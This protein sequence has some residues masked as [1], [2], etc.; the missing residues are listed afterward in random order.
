VKSASISCNS[1]L[2]RSVEYN[3]AKELKICIQNNTVRTVLL[4]KL[5]CCG[6]RSVLPACL[7]YKDICPALEEQIRSTAYVVQVYIGSQTCQYF[8]IQA[9]LHTLF[10]YDRDSHQSKSDQEGLALVVSIWWR[11]DSRLAEIRLQE[12]SD[13]RSIGVI[14]EWAGEIITDAGDGNDDVGFNWNTMIR[15]GLRH[16]DN[17]SITSIHLIIQIKRP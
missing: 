3:F 13:C 6:H 7:H 15:N 11:F 5:G 16:F 14:K 8:S 4:G 12:R 17:R 1:V 2:E 9:W 10:L